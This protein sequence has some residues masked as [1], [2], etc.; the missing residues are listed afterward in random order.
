METPVQRILRE[1][2]EYCDRE[3]TVCATCPYQNLCYTLLEFLNG[4]IDS[5]N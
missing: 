3:D 1:M 5:N 2:D 4:N